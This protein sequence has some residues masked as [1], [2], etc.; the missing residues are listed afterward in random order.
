MKR[1]PFNCQVTIPTPAGD[2]KA[3]WIHSGWHISWSTG[4]EIN[5]Y[6]RMRR[7]TKLKHCINQIFHFP[8]IFKQT[9]GG[10][11]ASD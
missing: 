11:N 4:Y 6:F 1:S 7:F 5:K 3:V 9:T 10:N 8:G 2:V